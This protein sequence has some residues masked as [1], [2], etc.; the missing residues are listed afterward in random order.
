MSQ[1]HWDV[2]KPNNSEA[3]VNTITFNGQVAIVTGAGRGIGRAHALEL[4]ARGASVV[5]NDIGGIGTSEGPWADAVVNE[6]EAA[7]GSAVASHDSVMTPEGGCAITALALRTFG[8]VDILINNAGF[9]RRGMFADMP[10]EHVREVI[11]VHLMGAFH[12]TQPAW[13]VMMAKGYGR[14]LMTSSAAAFGM[15]GNCNYA[16]AKAGLIGLSNAL[17]EEGRARG[18]LVNSILPYAKTMITVDS[19]A[20]GPDA[21]HNVGLQDA[22]GPR[23]TTGSVVAAALYLV[24]SQSAVTG[25]SISALAGRYARAFFALNAGWCRQDVETIRPEDF[26]DH[27]DEIMNASGIVDPGNLGGELE[28]VAQELESKFTC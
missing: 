28:I 20:V 23:M 2:A 10:M 13:K 1:D 12:V 3:M 18:V 5:V 22:L 7:G 4:A 24:S 9:L 26:A 19:P 11:D 14:V 6:I 25:D 27:I 17:A 21:K 8:T 15:Q 16:S